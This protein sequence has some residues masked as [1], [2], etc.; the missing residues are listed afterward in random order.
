MLAAGAYAELVRG[1][2]FG[3]GDTESARA[4]ASI[5]EALPAEVRALR[6][7]WLGTV[8]VGCAATWGVHERCDFSCT[9]CYLTAHANETPP[10]PFD[11]VRAQLDT[12]RR[13][14]GP[15]ANT[16][17][18]AG[19]VT[20]LPV[21]ELVRIVRYARDI[22][23]DPMVMTHGQTFVRDR[24]YLP[25]LM[26]EGGLRKIALHV[27]A[28]QRGRTGV[29]TRAT[30]RE[31]MSV[32]EELAQ[33]VRDARSTT[34]LPL[35]AD[36]TVTVTRDNIAELSDVI[37]WNVRNADVFRALGL[38]PVASVGR[39]R[40]HAGVDRTEVDAAIESALGRSITRSTFEMGHPDCHTQ[41]LFWVARAG[42]RVDIVEARRDGRWIDDVFFDDLARGAFRGFHLDDASSLETV[43]RLVGLFRRQPRYAATWP[44][45]SAYRLGGSLGVASRIVRAH[46]TGGTAFVRPFAL[47][48]HQFM[49]PRDLATTR[50]RERLAACTFKVPVDGRLVSMCEMNATSLRD[51]LGRDARDRLVPLGMRRPADV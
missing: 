24:A 22:G 28:T 49:Q 15:G 11:E 51:E 30:E 21:G 40:G 27:D 39:T 37:R 3:R 44:L 31:L 41:A 13:E 32:R 25:T 33:I 10:L 17:I 36:H 48:V 47:I 43:G 46:L 26:R 2:R 18:T 38:L 16:Q 12:I 7:Q 34:G 35:H 29:P 45:F 20:L 9:A 5:F 23:L 14:K 4:R 6:H 1:I 42:E 8:S 19:E 50:G